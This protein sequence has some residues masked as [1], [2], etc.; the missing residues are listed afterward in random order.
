LN[1]MTTLVNEYKRFSRGELKSVI[2]SQP[3]ELRRRL[4]AEVMLELIASVID[5]ITKAKRWQKRFNE[6]IEPPKKGTQ[7]SFRREHEVFLYERD[8]INLGKGERAFAY[9]CGKIKNEIEYLEKL[10]LEMNEFWTERFGKKVSSNEVI[11]KEIIAFERDLRS[12]IQENLGAFFG[13]SW[14]LRGIPKVI[15]DDWIVKRERDLKQGRTPEENLINYADF[16][17]YKEII[18]YN[19]KN[20]FSKYFGD[21]EQLRVR[22]DDLNNLLRISAMHARTITDDEIGTGRVC[23]RWLLSKMARV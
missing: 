19:W 10:A 20:I 21:K 23:M 8:I 18:I 6:I 12:F 16:S 11:Y 2:E 4:D 15:R 3:S 17:A 7:I 13:D 9:Y 14:I 22:L 5:D 1:E